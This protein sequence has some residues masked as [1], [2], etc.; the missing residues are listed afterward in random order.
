MPAPLARL[1]AASLCGG[2]LPSDW[3][4]GAKRHLRHLAGARMASVV[5]NVTGP[6]VSP[7]FLGE[8]RSPC[9]P[10]KWGVASGQSSH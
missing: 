4:G 5:H 1:G 10:R 7:A 3:D 9:D 2:G 6:R 8:G